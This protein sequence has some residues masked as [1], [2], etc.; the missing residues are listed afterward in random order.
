MKKST[1]HEDILNGK[2][3]NGFGLLSAGHLEELED[4]NESSSV[5]MKL[6]RGFF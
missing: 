2:K 3:G 1:A 4:F 5:S 6:K